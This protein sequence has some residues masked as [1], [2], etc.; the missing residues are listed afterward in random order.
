VVVGD[1]HT[2]TVSWTSTGVDDAGSLSNIDEIS[3]LPILGPGVPATCA[4]V[5]L[6][7]TI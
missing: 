1:T 4:T 6:R 7:I 3:I 5:D 2:V